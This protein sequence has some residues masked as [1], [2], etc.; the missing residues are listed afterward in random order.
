[1]AIE[2]IQYEYGYGYAVGSEDATQEAGEG[3]V[4]ENEADSDLKPDFKAL[5]WLVLFG[6]GGGLLSMYYASIG[7][8]PQVQ[9]EESLL[10]LGLMAILGSFFLLLFAALL[11]VPGRIWC[12]FLICDTYLKEA[13]SYKAAPEQTCLTSVLSTLA[14]PFG[15]YFATVHILLLSVVELKKL[16]HWDLYGFLF[17][18]A[19]LGLLVPSGYFYAKMKD[20]ITPGVLSKAD[21]KSHRQKLA[22]FYLLSMLSSLIAVWVI[23]KIDVP[24]SGEITQDQIVLAF[25]CTVVVLCV[26]V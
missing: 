17:M 21:C 26:N 23:N 20:K 22:G 7:Y 4:K 12:T 8:F 9:W 15:L 10:F 16:T 24:R 6:L 13:L 14:L 19:L 3:K 18:I 25:A 11:Y 1:M 2:H 5:E